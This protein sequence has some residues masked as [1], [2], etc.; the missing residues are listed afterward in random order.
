MPTAGRWASSDMPFRIGALAAP[1]DARLVAASAFN[2]KI[3]GVTIRRRDAVPM[4]RWPDGTSAEASA[5]TA[6]SSPKSLT[7]HPTASTGAA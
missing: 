5:P 7:S 1:A 6:Y 4:R 3:G 2:G